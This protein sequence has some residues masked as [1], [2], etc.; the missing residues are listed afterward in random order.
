MGY[1]YL[2]T[3]KVISDIDNVMDYLINNCKNITATK[4][5]LIKINKTIENICEFPLSYPDCSCFGIND[6]SIRHAVIKKY[7]LA[8]KIM[9]DNIVFLHF[10]HSKQKKII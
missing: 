7:I 8:F 5:L 1:S 10:K 9:D 3:N 6:C 2:L 4:N